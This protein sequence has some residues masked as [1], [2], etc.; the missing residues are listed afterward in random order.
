MSLEIAMPE[1]QKETQM[2][3]QQMDD[4]DY[5]ND[6]MSM[7]KYLTS[8][9]NVSLFETQNPQLYQKVQ[10][11]LIETHSMQKE[12]FDLMFEKGWYKMKAAEQQEIDQT[13]TQF[14]NYSNQFP[15]FH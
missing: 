9:Y 3:N 12:L 10:Q 4:R 14:T 11:A 2:R 1:N 7:E 5:V 8:S 15:S 13:K 6:I